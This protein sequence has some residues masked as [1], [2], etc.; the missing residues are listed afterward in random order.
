MVSGMR[1][2]DIERALRA[3]GC[4]SRS[5]KGSHTVW[6]C[7]CGQHMAIVPRHRDV[8]PGVVGNIIR[9]M[10]CLQEGWLR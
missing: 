8:S 9:T 3:Q 4:A 1:Y 2:R 5:G 7:P 6:Y 10:G